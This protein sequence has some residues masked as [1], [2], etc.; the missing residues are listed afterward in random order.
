MHQD[1]G[2]NPRFVRWSV[3]LAHITLAFNGHTQVSFHVSCQNP[4]FLSFV[5]ALWRSAFWICASYV[6]SGILYLCLV[7]IRSVVSNSLRPHVLLPARLFC[8]QDTPGKNTGVGCH[9]SSPEDLPYPGIE[10]RSPTLQEDFFTIWATRLYFPFNSLKMS[11]SLVSAL[12]PFCTDSDK[13][14]WEGHQ[15]VCGWHWQ[16][17]SN[18]LKL[19]F[20]RSQPRN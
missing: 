18:D 7:F 20:L 2:K 16:T 13:S 15:A 11:S 12:S 19:Y 3:T 8:P 10:P 1:Y 4:S 17:D 6:K 5:L 9:F 14:W